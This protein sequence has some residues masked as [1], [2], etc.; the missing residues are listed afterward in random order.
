MIVERSRSSTSGWYFAQSPLE[1]S[2]VNS[3]R[4]ASQ[5]VGQTGHWKARE[6]LGNVKSE[7]EVGF[8]ANSDDKMLLSVTLSVVADRFSAPFVTLDKPIVA[9]CRVGWACD[10]FFEDI[11]C[12]ILASEFRWS[13]SPFSIP[14]TFAANAFAATF[15]KHFAWV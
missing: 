11:L 9:G 2:D 7:A 12:R 15:C 4:T 14:S 10:D 8:N 1:I 3:A 6:R 13:V 5:G